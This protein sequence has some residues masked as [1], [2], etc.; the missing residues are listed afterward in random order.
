M[1]SPLAQQLKTYRD[2]NVIQLHKN[3][4]QIGDPRKGGRN[5]KMV[6]TVAI[7]TFGI[8]DAMR[9]RA[10]NSTVE[11]ISAGNGAFCISI[12]DAKELS[13]AIDEILTER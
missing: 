6:H 11:T 7:I 13:D 8:S 10:P 4:I 5:V 12:F 1:L 9:V 2:N 3:E